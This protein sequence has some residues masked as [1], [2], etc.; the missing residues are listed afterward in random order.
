MDTIGHTAGAVIRHTAAVG[1]K[2]E[3]A[4]TGV[5]EGAI[6]SAKGIG[7]TAEEAAAAAANG[8]LKA[9][10]SVGSKAVETVGHALTQTISGVKVVLAAPFARKEK[11]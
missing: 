5:V 8:A 6:E 10:G 4:A 1:G 9:A 7:V 3:H 2:L 11:R